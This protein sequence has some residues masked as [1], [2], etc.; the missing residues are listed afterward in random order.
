MFLY[1]VA[2]PCPH[3]MDPRNGQYK[4]DGP[5]ITGAICRLKCNRG[6]KVV[7]AKKRE[8]LNTS[9][10]SENNSFC[11]IL[12]CDELKNPENG[13]VILPCAAELGSMC[14]II[15]SPDFYTNST[16][17]TQKCELVNENT[18]EWSAPPSCI[19]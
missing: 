18:T 2:L 16:D 17:L 11:E 8:C 6:Y 19:G 5:Q 3:L 9:K 4:C 15:C 13:S 1:Y 7:G 14:R 12:H 10:W